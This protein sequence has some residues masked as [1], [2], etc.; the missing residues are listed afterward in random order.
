MA[1]PWKS[2]EWQHY[3]TGEREAGGEQIAA[4]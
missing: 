1:A 2:S 3:Q 4:T